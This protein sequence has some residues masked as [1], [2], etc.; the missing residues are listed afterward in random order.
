[1]TD[2]TTE[3]VMKIDL[4]GEFDL[5]RRDELTA[6]LEPAATA[7][8]AQLHFIDTT[9]MDSTALGCLIRLRKKMRD[10][11]PQSHIRIIAPSPQMR[12][13]FDIAGLLEIFEIDVDRAG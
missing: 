12:K 1:M 13:L 4:Y 5:S 9:Y 3:R 10:H 2:N 8:L 7:D 6:A 11:N